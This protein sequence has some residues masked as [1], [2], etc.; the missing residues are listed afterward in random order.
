[1][2]ATLAAETWLGSCS[3]IHLQALSATDI[4]VLHQHCF[5]GLWPEELC[6]WAGGLPYGWY[7]WM[8]SLQLRRNLA[9]M[10]VEAAQ[11]LPGVPRDAVSLLVS[12]LMWWMFV[13]IP[14]TSWFAQFQEITALTHGRDTQAM[15]RPKTIWSPSKKVRFPFSP[16]FWLIHPGMEKLRPEEGEKNQ[17]W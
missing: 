13:A 15:A 14:D 9:E 1:M 7:S 11:R 3:L 2:L 17:H 8:C 12:F 6:W 10:N 5:L 16:F 4:S